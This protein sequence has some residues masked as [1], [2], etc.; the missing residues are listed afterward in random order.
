MLFEKLAGIE[1]VIY[2]AIAFVLCWFIISFAL[3][4]TA[5]LEA[6]AYII[7]VK[8]LVFIVATLIVALI[9]LLSQLLLAAI[10]RRINMRHSR[11]PFAQKVYALITLMK[12]KRVA[13]KQLVHRV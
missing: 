5:L 10:R 1:M 8:M 2:F 12:F 3:G 6:L 11:N 13:K 7:A 9:A 4:A